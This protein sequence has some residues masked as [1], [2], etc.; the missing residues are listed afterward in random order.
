MIKTVKYIDLN[1]IHAPFEKEFI[2]KFEKVLNSGNFIMGG[3]LKSFELSFAKF[4]GTKYSIGVASGLDALALS[5]KALDIK[6]GDE[7]IVPSNTYIATFIAISLVGATPVL[8]E[9]REDTCNIDPQRIEQKITKKTKVI[10]PVHLYGQACEMDK[11]IKIAKKRK[12]YILE[13]NAQAHGAMYKKQTTGSFGIINATS[14]YPG[15]NLGALGDGG[16]ITTN[17]KSLSEKVYLLRNYGSK[18]KYYNDIIGYNSRLDEL[19]A[20]FLNIKLKALNK[21]IKDRQKIA[22]YY[23]KNLKNIG[24]LI[25]PITADGATHVYHIFSI[26]TGKRDKLQDF[27]NKKGIGTLIHYPVPPHLSKAYKFLGYKKGDFPIAEKLANTSLSIPISSAMTLK[28]ADYV[29]D[30]IKEFYK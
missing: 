17:N 12:I 23:I 27:L 21:I 24:D 28:E 14:F 16:A 10:I 15:K 5:L 18:I 19:Q 3:E 25:L 20:A 7:V 2:K 9:P 6:E 11:I 30:A 4:C 1:K 13:D 8:V 29:I 26:K 22:A